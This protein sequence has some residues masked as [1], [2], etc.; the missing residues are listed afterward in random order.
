MS[1]KI[2]FE[3]KNIP[4]NQINSTLFVVGQYK[5]DKVNKNLDSLFNGN[6]TTA[7]KVDSFKGDYNKIIELYGNNNIL[8]LS[9]VG[10]GDEKIFN[11]DKLRA[12]A[13]NII[14]NAESNKISSISID[15]DSFGLNNDNL[16]QAFSEGLM[17]GQYS[18]NHY[19]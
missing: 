10:L 15:S 1:N 5:S 2:S 4:Y 16:A 18:F 6:L 7:I 12:L 8:K 13:A 3:V 11:S 14:R 17:L 9:V 19:K